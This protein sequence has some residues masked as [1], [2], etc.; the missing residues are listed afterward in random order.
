MRSPLAKNSLFVAARQP[1][2]IKITPQTYNLELQFKEWYNNLEQLKAIEIGE[3]LCAKIWG[4]YLIRPLGYGIR[5]LFKKSIRG[6][7]INGSITNVERQMEK[8]Q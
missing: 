2:S 5:L 4:V 7:C 1:L 6:N 3:K 8:H